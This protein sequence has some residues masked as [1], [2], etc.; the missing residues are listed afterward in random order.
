MALPALVDLIID[1]GQAVDET[2]VYK[3]SNGDLVD[4]SA[5]TAKCEVREN[6]ADASPKLTITVTMDGA[7]GEFS[8]DATAVLTRALTFDR[9]FWSLEVSPRGAA[10]LNTSTDNVILCIGTVV[11]NKETT[12]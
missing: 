3:D 12:K 2:I 9:G 6:R 10:N 5:Y 11:V 4:N 7:S 8:L 1:Q